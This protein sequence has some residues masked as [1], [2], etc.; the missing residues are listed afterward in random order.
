MDGM[1]TLSPHCLPETVSCKSGQLKKPAFFRV[2]RALGGI[3]LAVCGLVSGMSA[4]GQTL[5]H[6]DFEDGQ[7]TGWAVTSTVTG[8]KPPYL[9]VVDDPLRSGNKVMMVDDTYK[10][11]NGITA[12]FT[13]VT[14]GTYQLS[15]Q[16]YYATSGGGMPENGYFGD[17]RIQ[18]TNNA[19]SALA[20][21]TRL[22]YYS[23]SAGGFRSYGYFSGG[24]GRGP[25]IDVNQWYE[26]VQ[27]IDLDNKTWSW[28]IRDLS[29]PDGTVWQSEIRPFFSSPTSLA[30]VGIWKVDN[31]GGVFLLDNVELKAIPEPG[32]VAAAL[33]V[34]SA[35][36]LM[37]RRR[38]LTR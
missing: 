7:T 38:S 37:R 19:V 15:L 21:Y 36:L 27:I 24:S 9:S 2:K 18:L 3:V 23:N 8:D 6:F 26:I 14:S 22:W 31:N 35:V 30:K 10:S 29:D 11:L 4:S 33:A 32:S 25:D 28:S 20:S 17:R 16:I 13:E 34:G 12:G 1:N 5:L